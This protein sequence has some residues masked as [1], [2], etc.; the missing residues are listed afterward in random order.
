[1]PVLASM[2]QERLV[3]QKFPMWL[4]F[5]FCCSRQRL[6][7]YV[8]VSSCRLHV[9]SAGVLVSS[10][11]S[12]VTKTLPAHLCST[13]HRCSPVEGVR[14]FS[15]CSVASCCSVASRWKAMRPAAPH[16]V[17]A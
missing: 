16:C 9:T 4:R 14:L 1:M 8:C 5:K 3:L 7:I 11:H 2:V 10:C 6:C 17:A 12:H 15:F 13:V